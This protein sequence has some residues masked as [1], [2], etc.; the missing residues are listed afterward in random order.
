MR[1]FVDRLNDDKL[2]IQEVVTRAAPFVF[3]Q[4]KAEKMVAYL[5]GDEHECIYFVSYITCL[6]LVCF[7]KN[8]D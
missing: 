3:D 6:P 8:H 7:S 4:F 5:I 1:L 2:F